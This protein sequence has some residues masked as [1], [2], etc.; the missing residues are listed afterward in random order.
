L[1]L[2]EID[3]EDKSHRIKDSFPEK[4]CFFSNLTDIGIRVIL[5]IFENNLFNLPYFTGHAFN[6][7]IERNSAQNTKKKPDMQPEKASFSIKSW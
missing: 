2:N 4:Q 1:R 6:G 7:L 5:H 3:Q